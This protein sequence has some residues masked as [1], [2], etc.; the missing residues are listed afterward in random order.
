MLLLARSAEVVEQVASPHGTKYVLDGTLATPCGDPLHLRT[1][2][3]VEPGH[4]APR[5]VTAYPR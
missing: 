1:V 3:I 4:E 5:F 2:W